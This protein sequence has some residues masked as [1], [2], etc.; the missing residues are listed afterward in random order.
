MAKRKLSDLYVRGKELT[1]DDGD[2]AVTVWLQKLNPIDHREA[3]RKADATRA[4]FITVCRDKDSEEYNQILNAVVGQERALM[5]TYLVATERLR[6]GPQKLS[7]VA[8]EPAWKDENYLNGLQDIWAEELAAKWADDPEDP[9]AKRVRAELDRY[10]DEVDKELDSELI[11]YREWLESD[12]D[13]EL[14]DKVIACQVKNVAEAAWVD[15]YYRWEMFFATREATDHKKRY[16]ES[17]AEVNELD[18]GVFAEIAGA[19]RE[20]TVDPSEGKDS[21]GTPPSSTSSESPEQLDSAQA[22]GPKDV[23]A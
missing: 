8:D 12:T 11:T 2:G 23:T 17:I 22:S 15:T 16:F 20:V 3:I 10:N 18:G 13:E 5:V 1:L 19:I 4:K 21:A 14:Q 7:E 9:E 6:L